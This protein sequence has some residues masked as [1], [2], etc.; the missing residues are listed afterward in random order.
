MQRISI[1]LM[2]IESETLQVLLTCA[3]FAEG[4]C[5]LHNFY[6]GVRSIFLH[7][8]HHH[9][10]NLLRYAGESADAADE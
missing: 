4:E 5:L 2:P 10:K 8:V 6:D 1:I 3:R 9:W 7:G